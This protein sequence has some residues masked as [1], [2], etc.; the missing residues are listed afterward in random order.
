MENHRISDRCPETRNL[1]VCSW[2]LDYSGGQSLKSFV[3]VFD[4]RSP[5]RVHLVARSIAPL[6]HG[7]CANCAEVMRRR[8]EGAE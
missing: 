8:A 6:T 3:Y 2:H 7:M 4:E 5:E 1:A